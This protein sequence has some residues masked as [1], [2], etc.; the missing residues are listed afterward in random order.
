MNI[1]V[2]KMNLK[3]PSENVDHGVVERIKTAIEA[4]QRQI[5]ECTARMRRYRAALN[6]LTGPQP[7]SLPLNTDAPVVARRVH[8][9]ST[10]HMLRKQVTQLLLE[11]QKPLS[12]AEIL[13]GLAAKGITLDVKDPGKRISKVMWDAK[14]FQHLPTGYWFAETSDPEV[15]E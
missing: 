14:E 8:M 6:A 15:S 12:R 3:N 7:T 11:Q 13:S 2:S 10:A 4:E 1:G 9:G 5:D